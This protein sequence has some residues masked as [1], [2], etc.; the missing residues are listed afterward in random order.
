MNPSRL[1]RAFPVLAGLSLLLLVLSGCPD[2]ISSLIAGQMVDALASHNENMASI[3]K[4]HREAV[5]KALAERLTQRPPGRPREGGPGGEGFRPRRRPGEGGPG[6]HGPLRGL[7][8]SRD[9]AA[10]YAG[11]GARE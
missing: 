5:V 6:A 9:E 1:R 8:P 4:E 3:L 10:E 7:Y 2:P 11:G